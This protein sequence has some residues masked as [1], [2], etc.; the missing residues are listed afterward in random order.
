M[1]SHQVESPSATKSSVSE[2]TTEKFSSFDHRGNVIAPFEDESKRD[3]EFQESGY[4]RSLGSPRGALAQRMFAEMNNMLLGLMLE[5]H[6]WSTARPTHESDSTAESLEMEINKIIETENEQGRFS[7]LLL[8]PLSLV[9]TRRS[10]V[11]TPFTWAEKFIHSCT[12][13]MFL[14]EKTRQR[15]NEFVDRI[16]MALAAL[17]SL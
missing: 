9:G 14:K 1:D 10:T 8:P 11:M 13:T 15:L 5:F 17:T 6:A 4:M 16:K 7:V 2:L 12:D 3:E